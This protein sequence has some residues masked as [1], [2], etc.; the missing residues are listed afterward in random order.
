[1]A[2]HLPK[3]GREAIHLGHC[4]VHQGRDQTRLRLFSRKQAADPE[5]GAALIPDK[6]QGTKVE[7]LI[8]PHQQLSGWGSP[9]GLNAHTALR[10]NADQACLLVGLNM[11]RNLAVM[12]LKGGLDHGLTGH[13]MKTPALGLEGAQNGLMQW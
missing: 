8:G 1:M 11:Q 4:G 6:L 12:R 2:T 13:L 10:H 7:G 5:Q 9:R 3:Q